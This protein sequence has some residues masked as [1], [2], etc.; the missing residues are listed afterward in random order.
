MS[1]QSNHF[2]PAVA[3]GADC[4]IVTAAASKERIES[5]GAAEDVVAVPPENDRIMEGTTRK[6]DGNGRDAR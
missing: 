4:S 6:S 1:V 3:F 5:L 2:G